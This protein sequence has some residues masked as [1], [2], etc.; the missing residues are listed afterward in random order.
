MVAAAL[1]FIS[2]MT[3]GALV[4]VVLVFFLYIALTLAPDAIALLGGYY[5]RWWW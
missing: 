1:Q 4:D 3:I 2:S 5:W